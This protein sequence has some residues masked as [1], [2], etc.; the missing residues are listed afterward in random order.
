[1]SMFGALRLHGVTAP[2]I[3]TATGQLVVGGTA[4]A[5]SGLKVTPHT[6]HG[7]EEP[8]VQLT[9]ARWWQDEAALERDRSEMSKYFPDFRELDRSD[10]PPEWIGVINTGRGRHTVTIAHQVD[11]GLPRVTPANQR[12]GRSKRG[13]WLHSPHR[14]LTGNLCF[15]ALEDWDPDRDSI[16]TVVAWVAHW[17]ACYNEWLLVGDWPVPGFSD[18]A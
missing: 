2:R 1:M 16:A 18:A 5:T 11:H 6:F 9:T 17:Y 14:Y 13:L 8:Q 10:G 15:A 3:V 12:L 4:A 7:G